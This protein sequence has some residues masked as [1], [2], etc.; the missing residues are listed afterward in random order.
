[1]ERIGGPSLMMKPKNFH[2]YRGKPGIVE[3][4]STLGGMVTGPGL[5]AGEKLRVTGCDAITLERA[6]AEIRRGSEWMGNAETI[7][8]EDCW[9]LKVWGGDAEIYSNE[10]EAPSTS[11]T[12]RD[13]SQ[14]VPGPDSPAPKGARETPSES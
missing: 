10:P 11:E 13:L 2:I 12:P 7:Q 8:G 4:Y 14:S 3:K 9:I 6:P 5:K 1:M